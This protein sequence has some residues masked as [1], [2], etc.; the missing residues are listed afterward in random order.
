MKFTTIEGRSGSGKTKELL[1]HINVNCENLVITTEPSVYYIEKILAQ[2][3]IPANV[4]AFETLARFILQQLNVIIGTEINKE[5][6]IIMIGKV[7]KNNRDRLQTFNKVNFENSSINKIFVCSFVISL[8][9]WFASILSRG[10]LRGDI[11]LP[12]SI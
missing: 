5:S 3:N 7:I 8:I 9:S 2:K 12:R 4:I 10:V 6:Q 11:I 1:N